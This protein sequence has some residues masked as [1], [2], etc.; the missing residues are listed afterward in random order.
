MTVIRQ[1]DRRRTVCLWVC[2]CVYLSVGVR[3]VRSVC[4]CLCRKPSIVVCLSCPVCL[5]VSSLSQ[6]WITR[7][8]DLSRRFPSV[9]PTHRATQPPD[10]HCSQLSADRLT[11]RQSVK[12]S[13]L[14]RAAQSRHPPTHPPT[15]V[16][17]TSPARS[18]CRN[19]IHRSS[20]P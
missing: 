16:T 10:A 14:D 15:S 17:A 20:P 19:S 3:G 6:W 1:I 2:G 9:S 8:T 13:M 11:D 7:L 4:V 18:L 12:K 5:L